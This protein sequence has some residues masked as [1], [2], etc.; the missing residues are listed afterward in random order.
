MILTNYSLPEDYSHTVAVR[1][2]TVAQQT[3]QT[4]A[5]FSNCSGPGT[6]GTSGT[7]SEICHVYRKSTI[8]NDVVF[9]NPGQL[10]FMTQQEPSTTHTLFV[11]ACGSR[12]SNKL[13]IGEETKV[14]IIHTSRIQG[15]DKNVLKAR[16]TNGTSGHDSTEISE[17]VSVHCLSVWLPVRSSVCLS[18]CVS[19]H[20]LNC[21]SVCLLRRNIC[22]I[23]I[24]VWEN[25]WNLPF[26]INRQEIMKDQRSIQWRN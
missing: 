1:R 16:H 7:G 2:T 13:T 22:I 4:N 5:G 19:V 11:I 20:H 3:L 25:S 26:F 14:H 21:L 24:V 12:K 18:F 15:I 8:D 23:C 6:C 17:P 9:I 10:F